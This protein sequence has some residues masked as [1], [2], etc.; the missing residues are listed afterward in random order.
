MG[1]EG[2]SGGG[3]K[4]LMTANSIAITG[5]SM[6]V[7]S[8]HNECCI[9]A[10]FGGAGEVMLVAGGGGIL[11]NQGSRVRADGGEG[12]SSGGMGLL[13]LQ[14]TGSINLTGAQA[15]GAFGGRAEEGIGGD[16]LTTLIAGGSITV[17]DTNGA[18]FSPWGTIGIGVFAVGGSSIEGPGGVGGNAATVYVA[19]SSILHQNSHTEAVSG[20]GLAGNGIAVTAMATL[21]GNISILNTGGI[22]A[23]VLA[24]ANP[25]C[26]ANE[27]GFAEVFLQAGGRTGKIIIEDDVVEAVGAKGQA[28]INL[29]FPNQAGPTGGWSVNGVDGAITG[30]PVGFFV[31]GLPAE[32][33]VNFFAEYGGAPQAPSVDAPVLKGI[34]D[35]LAIFKA[36]EV[37]ADT[38]DKPGK[39]EKKKGDAEC[40]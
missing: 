27:G 22:P 20:S 12:V 1:G 17:S 15:V 39:D 14:T 3:G 7:G 23:T 18:E 28:F 40:S 26:I 2:F 30:S 11:I 31:N 19:G 24:C 9:A 33:G 10:D 38:D 6:V 4:V 21:N 16:A 8:G 34:D 36:T 37:S 32:P 35:I 5:E 25:D 13:T 29:F